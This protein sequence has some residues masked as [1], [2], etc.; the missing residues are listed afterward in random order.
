MRIGMRAKDAMR[1]LASSPSETR[2]EKRREDLLH[3][4]FRILIREGRLAR[5]HHG[6]ATIDSDSQ[7]TGILLP[8]A[9]AA[10]TCC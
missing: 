9:S 7:Y 4:A 1:S 6:A 3:V 10:A 2:K 8:C 5:S